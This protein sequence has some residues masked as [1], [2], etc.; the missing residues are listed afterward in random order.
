ML[1]DGKTPSHI[2]TRNLLPISNNSFDIG[3]DDLKLKDLSLAGTATV[4]TLTDGTATL[5][6][7]AWTG[8]TKLSIA[9]GTANGIYFGDGDTG[10]WEDPDDTFNLDTWATIANTGIAAGSCYGCRM[11]FGQNS[12]RTNPVFLPYKLDANTGLGGSGANQDELSLIAGGVEG[13][14]VAETGLAITINAFGDLI[15]TGDSTISGLLTVTGY[16]TELIT[17]GSFTGGITGWTAGNGWEH[18]T[19]A[20]IWDNSAGSG[21]LEQAISIVNGTEYKVVFTITNYGAPDGSSFQATLGGTVIQAITGDGTFTNMVTAGAGG[22]FKIECTAGAAIIGDVLIVDTVTVTQHPLDQ[23]IGGNLVFG[24]GQAGVDYY[25]KANG[26][27]NDGLIYW[28]EDEDYWEFSD[29][30]FLA[31]T[32]KIVFRDTNISISSAT[33]GHLDLVADVSVDLNTPI[34][35]IASGTDIDVVVHFIATTHSGVLT[36]MEDEDYFLFGDAIKLPAGTTALAPLMFTAG[37]ALT[38]PVAGALEFHDS[39]LYVT[40]KATRKAIDR[41]S[42]VK[43]STTTVEN[44]TDETVVYTAAA[45]AASWVAGNILKMVMSGD[46]TNA[47]ASSGHTVTINVKVGTDTIATVTS[48][49]AKFTNACW[50]LNGFAIVRSIGGSGSMAWHMDLVVD[51]DNETTTCGVSTIDTTGALDITVTAT[52]A[53]ANAGNIF[54]CTMGL[55]EYKN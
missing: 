12:S 36:W 9:T 52:W 23:V 27:S 28:R 24:Q 55:M 34:L 4:G 46:I 40:N 53:T 35:N 8:L 33:D 2:I 16:G 17:N 43:T 15:T 49:A 54:T 31:D 5:T 11:C 47:A 22:S 1:I 51:G 21:D 3:S 41:T 25:I 26:E 14:R 30:L 7:G 10:I 38:T 37:T 18:S 45:P 50:H 42:D 39:R 13:L 44:T 48:T 19:N 29:T 32:R 6:L 20:A